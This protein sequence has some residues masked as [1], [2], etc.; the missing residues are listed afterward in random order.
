MNFVEKR[1]G[2]MNTQISIK[3]YSRLAKVDME[4][5][6]SEAFNQFHIV[7]ARFT[8]F[9]QSSEVG[10]LNNSNGKATSVSKELFELVEFGLKLGKKTDWIFDIT[11]ADIL[12]AYGYDQNYSFEKLEDPNLQDLIRQLIVNR[13][14][15]QDIIL[16]KKNLII[17]LSP[18]QKIDLGAYAKGYA[19]RLARDKLLQLGV[20]KFLINAGGDVY[21][22]GK[23]WE[24]KL[25]DPVKTLKTGKFETVKSIRLR[26]EAV[27]CSGPWARKIKFF[28]HLVNPKTGLPTRHKA[29][30]AFVRHSDPMYADAL[31]TINYLMN[32]K[33]LFF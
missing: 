22:H 24:V 30:I 5:A 19:I 28:H 25:F 21:A 6:I 9:S 4:N 32:K 27:A 17:K 10:I 8:R 20:D 2:L 12:E 14:K 13:P 33:Q 1:I 11:V 18:N 3:A 29:Q 16:D 26:N 31:A 7:V 23:V 15:P